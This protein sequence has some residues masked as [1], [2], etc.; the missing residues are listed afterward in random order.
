[1]LKVNVANQLSDSMQLTL[2]TEY[3]FDDS[4]SG[5]QNGTDVKLEVGARFNARF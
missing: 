3:T 4:H 5:S 2:F 1:M